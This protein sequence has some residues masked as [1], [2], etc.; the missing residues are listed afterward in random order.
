VV[1][2]GK[3]GIEGSFFYD[4]NGLAA[5]LSNRVNVRSCRRRYIY[6]YSLWLSRPFRVI[7]DATIEDEWR[8]EEGGSRFDYVILLL[9]SP[10][11]TVVLDAE[12]TRYFNFKVS[13]QV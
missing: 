8:I 1:F 5:V 10:S 3:V 6:I 12:V 9:S 13:G 4:A 11:R 7:G 2:V